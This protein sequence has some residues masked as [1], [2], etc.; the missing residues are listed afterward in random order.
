MIELSFVEM[1][2]STFCAVS[3]NTASILACSRLE[4]NRNTAITTNNAARLGTLIVNARR[5]QNSPSSP[6]QIRS[7]G[8]TTTTPIA[9]PTHQFSQLKENSPNAISPV[10][11]NT[12]LPIV[13]LI[14]HPTGPPSISN[15]VTVVPLRSTFG[16]TRALRSSHAETTACTLA[17]Q[18]ITTAAAMTRKSPLA[19]PPMEIQRLTASEPAPIAGQILGPY[20]SAAARPMPA[21]G[22]IAVA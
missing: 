14:T 8:V 20:M 6:L 2:A 10:D 11:N 7:N 1:A 19:T 18:A 21:D 16:H 15:C 3:R 4:A 17:P 5:R 22:Q 9:S 12:V 13:A